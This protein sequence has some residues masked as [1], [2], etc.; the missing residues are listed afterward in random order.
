MKFTI[1]GLMLF[2]AA[3]N[4]STEVVQKVP[5]SDP[6]LVAK[7]AALTQALAAATHVQAQQ[8]E[9]ISKL[10]LIGKVH[11]VASAERMMAIG[12]AALISPN[13]GPCTDMGVLVGFTNGQGRPADALTATGQDFKQCTGYQYAVD[14][15]TGTLASAER[16]FWDGPN[17][18]GN[19]IVWQSAGSGYNT[20]ALQ[21]G[22]VFLSPVDGTPLMVK[23][24]QTPKPIMI[25]SA[26]ISENPGC[27]S[28][29]ETQLMYQVSAN[30]T[31]VSGIP[32]NGVGSYQLGAP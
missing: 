27:Q 5:Y 11:G 22:V 29:V 19:M 28:D 23:S 30:D 17:C 21:G 13:F 3:C 6:A 14:I 12:Q 31:S 1:F 4:G 24:G 7:I 26:W 9:S 20:A 2:L 15:Q 18:T 25:Q 10:Q 16:V 32:D 8:V